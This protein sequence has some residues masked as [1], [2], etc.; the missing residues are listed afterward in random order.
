MWMRKLRASLRD[1]WLLLREFFWP[2]VLFIA[3]M[4][5]GGTL[6]YAL[7]MRAGE[8]IANF[9]EAIYQ[10]L[11]LTFLQSV[12][13]FPSAWYLEL[14]F[15]IMPVVGLII[16][17]QGIAEFGSMFFNRQQRGKEWEMAVASTLQNHHVLVGLGHLGYRVVLHLYEL[18]QDVVAV[19][20]NPSA[21]LVA[22][23]KKLGIPVIQDDAN[24]DSTLEAAGIQKARSII[25]CTQ[26]DSLNLQVALKA[27]R[28]NKNI[29]VLVRIFDE[30]FAS[31]LQEQFG[32]S[33]LSATQM[34]APVFAS[35]AA[36][37]EM[38]QPITVEGK[39]L[40]LAQ[41]TISERSKLVGLSVEMVEQ[42]FDVSVVL[43]RRNHQ[44][45]FHPSAHLEFH[46]GDAV[47]VLGGP[48]EIAVLAQENL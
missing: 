5:G 25:L 33:A 30:E 23:V 24:R 19:E 21:D 43:V 36:G 42:N 47:A 32:F 41:L 14:F 2:L 13:N 29:Q 16:L 48:S 18:G 9:A 27:R 46:I 11:S 20:L 40:S 39:S 26:K 45:D 31:A 38:T 10:V 4:V 6:Y 1:T 22:N 35:A 3:A 12:G 8:P 44:S 7:S 28:L 17:S 34:A 37:V 15:F